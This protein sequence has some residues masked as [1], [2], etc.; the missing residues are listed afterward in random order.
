[1]VNIRDLVTRRLE[2][3]GLLAPAEEGQRPLR[4]SE[5]AR[6]VGKHR[7]TLERYRDR[8]SSGVLLECW[9]EPDRVWYSTL[10]NWTRFRERVRQ[11]LAEQH[12]QALE[13]RRRAMEPC[14][15]ADR[16]ERQA[17]WERARRLNE[18]AGAR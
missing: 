5:L 3:Q 9:Q 10:A 7:D 16:C 8:G 1:M 2:T 14:S 11:V 17:R 6:L 12:R 15:E 4:L 18:E 13:A